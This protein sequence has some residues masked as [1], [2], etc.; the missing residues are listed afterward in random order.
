MLV[1]SAPSLLILLHRCLVTALRWNELELVRI[2]IGAADPRHFA[3]GMQARRENDA[4]R[5]AQAHRAA[6]DHDDSVSASTLLAVTFPVS[7][8]VK[9]APEPTSVLF[10]CANSEI[11]VFGALVHESIAGAQNRHASPAA[12]PQPQACS[13]YYT[14]SGLRFV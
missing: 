2:T 8:M 9:P 3:I 4:D 12:Q 7:E 1:T 10:D 5:G 13:I 6:R 11:I 14:C